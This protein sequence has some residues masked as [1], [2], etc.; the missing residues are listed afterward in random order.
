[1]KVSKELLNHQI[2]LKS[3]LVIKLV[4]PK[5]IPKFPF[6]KK[7]IIN[8]MIALTVSELRY[9]VTQVVIS[10]KS[11]PQLK[12]ISTKG[13][14]NPTI[15][16]NLL[17]IFLFLKY[18]TSVLIVLIIK[19]FFLNY[20]ISIGINLNRFNFI[21]NFISFNFNSIFLKSYPPI[22]LKLLNCVSS[23]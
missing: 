22:L 6:L 11:S 1:M 10:L 17:P 12:A 8:A 19:H 16:P 23:V 18:I 15:Y 14:K 5:I 7:E 9:K 2:T 3:T 21:T 13:V 4:I 20:P